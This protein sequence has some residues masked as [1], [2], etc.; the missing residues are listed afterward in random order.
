MQNDIVPAIVDMFNTLGS[1]KL[2]PKEHFTHCFD[3]RGFALAPV[4]L[5]L[6]VGVTHASGGGYVACCNGEVFLLGYEGEV[7]GWLKDRGMSH[8]SALDLLLTVNRRN[9]NRII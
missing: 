7:I 9:A 4:V 8:K 1:G 2:V 6:G 5:S 3:L